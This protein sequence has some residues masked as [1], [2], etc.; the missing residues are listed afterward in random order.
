V[1][2]VQGSESR[3]LSGS[4]YQVD[5]RDV[6]AVRELA[7]D[8]RGSDNARVGALINLLTLN[9]PVSQPG[10]NGTDTPLR[11]V[12][13]LMNVAQVFEDDIR[14]S[15]R[16][17]GGWLV[18]VTTLGGR[19]GLQTERDLPVAQAGSLGF[20]KS[21][22]REWNGVRVKNLDLDP[23]ADPRT[24]VVSLL[25]ELTATDGF[26]EVG[27]DDEG[28]WRLELVEDSSAAERSSTSNGGLPL[29]RDAV[30]L[31]TGGADGITAEVLKRLAGETGARL[32][33]VGRSPRSAAGDEPE[34]I[35]EIGDEQTMRARMIEAMRGRKDTVTPA[36]VERD[37]QRILKDRRIRANL[38][39]FAAAGSEVEYHSLDVRDADALGGLIDDLYTRF[40][41]IDGVLHGAGVVEDSRVGDKTADSFARVFETK[42]NSAMTLAQKLRPDG[43]RFLVLF[44]SV[45]GRFGNAGQTDY[46]AAN[47]YLNKLAAQ[48]DHKWPGRVVAINWGPWDTGMVS[49]GLRS[50]YASRGIEL[51][52]AEAGARS[53][54]EELCLPETREAEVV[55]TCT[56]RQIAGPGEP[57]A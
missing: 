9:E 53:L 21:L 40:G 10:L 7:V 8:I 27:L 33:I 55:L 23:D 51:I 6:A 3:K 41:R 29:D 32:V 2:L 50:A 24:L 25:Q 22:A 45:S 28:R 31:A 16:S 54:L 17:G 35:R 36:E 20:F 46:S 19:F 39:A 34:E 14:E 44:S 4:R 47:E 52:Q 26:V 43:L 38:E 15:G 49:D 13:S 12:Q 57:T 37:L 5:L 11:L 18:N 30:V 48:L 42:V 1:Q 56:P